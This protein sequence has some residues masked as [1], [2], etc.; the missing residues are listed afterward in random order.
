M[1]E[2]VRVL[3]RQATH[4]HHV[5]LNRHPML[6]GLAQ[7]GFSLP[8][9]RTLLIA[10]FRLYQAL[11][12]QITSFLDLRPEL[13]DYMSRQKLPWLIQDINF[14]Q[15][16]SRASE[17][18]SPRLMEMPSMESAGSLVGVLYV[19]EGST[20]GGQHISAHLAK[21]HSL[22]SKAGA[23]FFYGYGEYT[24]ANWG[25]FLKFADSIRESAF[26]CAAAEKSAI[27]TFNLFESVLS[28]CMNRENDLVSKA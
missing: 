20:L 23:R 27:F 22:S 13:F 24:E 21:L 7:P 12:M 5:R 9:Y 17:W 19:I 18:L 15:D 28:E 2:S 26:D 1:Q 16:N 8:R 14:F 25:A 6:N 11:E 10:Y 3:L 4:G